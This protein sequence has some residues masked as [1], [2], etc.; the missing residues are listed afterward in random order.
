MH[1]FFSPAAG[2][3]NPNAPG[4]AA[5]GQVTDA[6]NAEGDAAVSG[7]VPNTDGAAAPEP[8]N[9]EGCPKTD[10]DAPVPN[11]NPGACGVVAVFA[12]VDAAGLPKID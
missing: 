1:H 12:S 3:P 5:V 11:E 6:P 7:L 9:A 10:D 8:P 4:P 2:A